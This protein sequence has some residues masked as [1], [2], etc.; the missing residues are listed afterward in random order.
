MCIA[1]T[2]PGFIDD[3][4][5]A[6]ART[7]DYVRATPWKVMAIAATIGWLIGR[8]LSRAQQKP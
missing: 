8:L 3:A 2:A 1:D 6:I 7:H 4:Q 5:R